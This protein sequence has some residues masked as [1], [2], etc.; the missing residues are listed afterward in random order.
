MASIASKIPWFLYIYSRPKECEKRE[1]DS[2]YTGVI[3][4]VID[5]PQSGVSSWWA[6]SCSTAVRSVIDPS[7]LPRCRS[8]ATIQRTI[9]NIYRRNI[10][11]EPRIQQSL[12]L[13]RTWESSRYNLRA[14]IICHNTRSP[15]VIRRH[16]YA[17]TSIG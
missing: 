11:R 9:H 12:R 16:S 5:Q 2:S 6:G 15:Y 1:P 3:D 14:H 8:L 7:V 13:G 17:V 10:I 4:E